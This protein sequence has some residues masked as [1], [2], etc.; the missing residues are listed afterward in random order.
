MRSEQA[1]QEALR[2]L[3]A[4][5][6]TLIIAHRLSTVRAADEILVLT[7]DGI[8][9]RGAHEQLMAAGG[10]YADPLR[11]ADR[12]GRGRGGGGRGSPGPRDGAQEPRR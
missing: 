5:R 4:G 7:E 2:R 9:Q 11:P 8:V 3:T 10:V 6:T 12:G 1:V